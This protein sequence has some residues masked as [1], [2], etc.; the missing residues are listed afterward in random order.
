MYLIHVLKKMRKYTFSGFKKKS[1][2]AVE[3]SVTFAFKCFYFPSGFYIVDFLQ[4]HCFHPSLDTII[5]IYSFGAA[6]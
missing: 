3:W 6:A 4:M 5:S 1:E 2:F